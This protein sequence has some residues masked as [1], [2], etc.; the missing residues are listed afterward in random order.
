M[1][2]AALSS[3]YAN[4]IEKQK[5]ELYA[6]NEEI[7]EL[8]KQNDFVCNFNGLQQNDYCFITCNLKLKEHISKLEAYNETLN[9]SLNSK[10][11]EEKQQQIK[12]VTSLSQNN[13]TK[14]A[15]KKK[16]KKKFSLLNLKHLKKNGQFRHCRTYV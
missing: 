8:K 7:I 6:K 1:I 13:S 4:I 9:H 10:Q 3:D 16:K 2:V 14:N 5:N 15:T 12:A 11:E